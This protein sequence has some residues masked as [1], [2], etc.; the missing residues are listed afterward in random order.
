MVWNTKNSFWPLPINANI[1]KCHIRTL[2]NHW[3][4]Q[5]RSYHKTELTKNWSIEK[6][7]QVYLYCCKIKQQKSSQKSISLL[8]L[9]KL[10][11]W[12]AHD[13]SVQMIKHVA[14]RANSSSTTSETQLSYAVSNGNSESLCIF[15]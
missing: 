15:K 4:Y 8:T 12:F 3:H 11:A 14:Q 9:N 7:Y 10:S 6:I 1:Y 5:N 13:K 2:F